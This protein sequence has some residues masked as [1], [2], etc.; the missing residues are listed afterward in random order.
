MLL[1]LAF[2]SSCKDDPSQT[3]AV[4]DK[5]YDDKV[6]VRFAA[7]PS[8]I[9]PHTTTGG[10][11]TQIKNL[12][13]AKLLEVDF[14]TLELVPYLAKSLP[15]IEKTSDG[16]GL[17]IT[18]EIR[19]EA[20]WD[21]GKPITVDDVEFSLKA[22]KNPKVNAA[23]LRP[24]L[25][26]IVEVK[27]YPDNPKKFTF[28]CDRIY[29]LAEDVSGN[30]FNI[31]PKHLYDP[32]GLSDKISFAQIVEGEEDVMNS[33]DNIAFAKMFNDPK[34]NREPSTAHGAGAYKL[35]SWDTGQRIKFER[36]KDWWGNSLKGNGMFFDRGPQEVEYSIINDITTAI[37][38]LKGGHLDIL[39]GIPSKDWLEL[40]QKSE[41]YKKNFNQTEIPALSYAYMG[42][43][44]RSDKLKNKKTRHAIYH[45][46]DIEGLIEQ[47]NYGLSIPISH[48]ILPAM[49][50]HIYKDIPRREFN[51]EKAKTL[52]A[53]A[54]WGDENGNG[55][56]DQ[57][58]DGKLTEL[59]LRLSYRS[60]S[61][62]SKSWVLAF[63]EAWKSA[64]IK[65]EADPLEWS[66]MLERMKS[67][68]LDMWMSSFGFDPRP[69]DPKQLYH[70]DSYNGG[71]NYT[72]FGNDETDQII[73]AIATAVTK[74]EQTKLFHQWQDILVEEAP[75]LYLFK[76][77]NRVSSHK[78]FGDIKASERNPG[79]HP[80]YFQPAK[81]Y[82]I[83]GWE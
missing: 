72:G 34:L 50:K 41:K 2:V 44:L 64:G 18:Y 66:V 57:R 76:G 17:E 14:P 33:V 75:V 12:I 39:T 56:L 71:S 59:V 11:A 24:Y 15:I 78:R 67:H 28:I 26:F 73:E 70:T 22:A 31:I 49:G 65:V 23:N 29:I 10:P 60:G 36:K 4:D 80:G 42:F 32:E 58:F 21:D 52:L 68:K 5:V 48:D 35:I 20:V 69:M 13:H 7:D 8:G 53:E 27:R 1:L 63:Q 77:K 81:G 51:P 61:D 30:E 54:G 40:P 6:V 83:K 62:L 74:E 16:K 82:K 46:T 79:Y 19:E 3:P 37:A 55:I 43:N 9:H 47:L 25:D 38:A 45:L